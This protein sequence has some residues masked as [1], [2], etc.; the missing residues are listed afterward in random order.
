MVKYIGSKRALVPAISAL[1]AQLPVRT[2][3]DLFAGTT[4]VGQALRAGGL[5]VH[6][7]DLA[8]YSEI[9]G[10]AYIAADED[11]DRVRVA[12]ILCELEKL[13]GKD[14]YFTETFCQQSRFIQPHN[15]RR[16]D[17]IRDAV[18]QL[19]LDPIE[20]GIVLTSLVE[21]ADRVDSTCGLQMAYVKQ[22][23]KRSYNDLQLRMPAAVG[24]PAGVVTRLDANELATDLDA[25]DLA[26][27]DPPYNQHSYFANYHV[28][29]TLV[30]WD[31]P[32]HYGIACKREDCREPE[33]KSDYNSKRRAWQA[34]SGLI[35]RVA[36]PWMIVSFSNEGYHDP[37]DLLALLAEKGYARALQVDHDRYVGAKIGIH[38]PSGKKVGKVSHVRN[39]EYLFVVGPDRAVI[40]GLAGETA[41]TESSHLVAI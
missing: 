27:I 36:S 16:I 28:W 39:H 21:A 2:A 30:R 10:Q 20:R 25:V 4:R 29:E 18:D 26:Y 1:A 14:G 3:C 24:G 12:A 9:F 41:F 6:S 35:E 15:G 13:P 19:E 37:R 32:Q 7:N 31:A 5:R 33:N 23:A 34:F 11:V 22:W 8:T 17:A 40:D 38:S